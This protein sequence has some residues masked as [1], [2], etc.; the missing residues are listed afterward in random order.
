[1][2]IRAPFGAPT[3]SKSMPCGRLPVPA[4]VRMLRAEEA[5]EVPLEDVLDV[6]LSGMRENTWDPLTRWAKC[7]GLSAQLLVY[8]L[9]GEFGGAHAA[10]LVAHPRAFPEGCSLPDARVAG[11]FDWIA[12]LAREAAAAASSACP[13][14]GLRRSSISTWRTTGTTPCRI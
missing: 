4:A 2:P 14:P 5:A 9:L 12:R 7:C 3:P 11:V 10:A 1:M 6:L 13:C 8:M